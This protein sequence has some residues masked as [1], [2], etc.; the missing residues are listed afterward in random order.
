MKLKGLQNCGQTIDSMLYGAD[1][2]ATTQEQE[3]R[4]GVNDTRMLIWMCEVT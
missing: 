1:T 2:G 4:L 3:A